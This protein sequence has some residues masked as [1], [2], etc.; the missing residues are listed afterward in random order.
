VVSIKVQTHR[1]K[2]SIQQVLGNKAVLFSQFA[3]QLTEA[4]NRFVMTGTS[5]GLAL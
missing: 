4:T 1:K 3:V 5:L 2:T